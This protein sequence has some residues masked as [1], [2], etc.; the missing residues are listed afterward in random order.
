MIWYYVMMRCVMHL[1]ARNKHHFQ[2]S[3]QR[4]LIKNFV[5]ATTNQLTN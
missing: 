3:N 5:L 1:S 4:Q 2:C